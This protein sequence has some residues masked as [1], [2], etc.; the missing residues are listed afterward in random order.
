ME[1]MR[2]NGGG[3]IEPLNYMKSGFLHPKENKVIPNTNIKET[4]TTKTTFVV[5]TL[6]SYFANIPIE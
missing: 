4:Q 2:V 1:C 5:A 6:N 3:F